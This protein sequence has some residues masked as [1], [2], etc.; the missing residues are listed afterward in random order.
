MHFREADYTRLRHLRMPWQGNLDTPY[1][2]CMLSGVVQLA[3][4]SANGTCAAVL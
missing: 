1:W 2:Q 4:C 3:R